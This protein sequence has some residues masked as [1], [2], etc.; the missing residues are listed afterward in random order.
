MLVPI[1]GEYT[2]IA[3]RRSE[4][5]K[6]LVILTPGTGAGAWSAGACTAGVTGLCGAGAATAT[7]EDIP[8]TVHT[9]TAPAISPSA[10]RTNLCRMSLYSSSHRYQPNRSSSAGDLPL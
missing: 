5:Q 7:V 4:Y 10:P 8:S 3:T 1:A 9:D 2:H 6:V